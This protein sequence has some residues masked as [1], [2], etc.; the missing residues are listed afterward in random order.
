MARDWI[1]VSGIKEGDVIYWMYFHCRRKV[2]FIRVGSNSSE[3]FKL[4]K[5]LMVQFLARVGGSDVTA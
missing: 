2:Q 3:N 4:A 5:T 1:I